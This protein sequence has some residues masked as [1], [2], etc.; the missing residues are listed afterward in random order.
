MQGG[1]GFNEISH[2]KELA[3]KNETGRIEVEEKKGG[4]LYL[5]VARSGAA[6]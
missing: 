6:D 4:N 5:K 3:N 2:Y 1:R